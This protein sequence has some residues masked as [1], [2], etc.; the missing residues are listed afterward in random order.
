MHSKNCFLAGDTK[1]TTY[2]SIRSQPVCSQLIEEPFVTDWSL[3]ES[4]G[5]EVRSSSLIWM[6][7]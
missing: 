4:F 2:H 5:T 3:I 7:E 6:Y 1:T